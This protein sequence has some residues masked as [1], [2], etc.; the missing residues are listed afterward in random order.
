MTIFDLKESPLSLYRSQDFDFAYEERMAIGMASTIYFLFSG[1]NSSKRGYKSLVSLPTFDRIKKV[2]FSVLKNLFAAGIEYCKTRDVS[3]RSHKV[4]DMI[5]YFNLE[6]NV[7]GSHT[8]LSIAQ[9]R[10]VKSTHD[11]ERNIYL[12]VSMLGEF[13]LKNGIEKLVSAP[14]NKK[15]YSINAKPVDTKHKKSNVSKAELLDLLDGAIENIEKNLAVIKKV[16]QE[17]AK[18]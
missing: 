5:L 13:L 9:V 8:F 10:N 6:G 3:S 18:E 1:I 16:R 14:K 2:D 15:V 17:L 7:C 11:I 4:A 12:T